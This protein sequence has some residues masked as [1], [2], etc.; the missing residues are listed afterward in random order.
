[1]TTMSESFVGNIYAEAG[2]KGFLVETSDGVFYEEIFQGLYVYTDLDIATDEKQYFRFESLLAE[3]SYFSFDT[4]YTPMAPPVTI[5]VRC[6]DV[7][8]LNAYPEVK[9]TIRDGERQIVKKQPL[10]FIPYKMKT[11]YYNW[12][13]VFGTDTMYSS[14]GFRSTLSGWVVTVSSY[15]V[16]DQEYSYYLKVRE[17]LTATNQIF[18][19]LPSSLH[20]NIKCITNEA[21]PVFGYFSVAAKEVHS[22]AMKWWPGSNLLVYKPVENYPY[23]QPLSLMNDSTIP[24]GWVGF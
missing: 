15:S 22:M 20:G 14:R 10:G 8:Y 4:T 17:Q 19:P 23:T 18:D 9:A 13:Y 6:I 11:K 16:S 1:M 21:E 12:P 7:S 2:E 3:Q 5:Y 24:E